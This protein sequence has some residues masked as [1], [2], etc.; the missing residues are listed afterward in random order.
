MKKSDGIPKLVGRFIS[1]VCLGTI[2]S[3]IS[4]STAKD[5]KTAK[6]R[7]SEN[8]IIDYL[9]GG[10]NYNGISLGKSWSEAYSWPGIT[11]DPP[12]HNF[13]FSPYSNY[14]RG[15]EYAVSGEVV[16]GPVER[17]RMMDLCKKYWKYPEKSKYAAQLGKEYGKLMQKRENRI[18]RKLKF[19]KELYTY[20][21]TDNIKNFNRQCQRHSSNMVLHELRSIGRKGEGGTPFWRFFCNPKEQAPEKI[22]ICHIKYS[23]HSVPGLKHIY[24]V[25]Y[26]DSTKWNND[27][28]PYCDADARWYLVTLD[29]EP[30][31]LRLEGT[32][33][34]ILITGIINPAMNIAYCEKKADI[35]PRMGLY[36]ESISR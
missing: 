19:L 25:I 9:R 32:G 24:P 5:T 28:I 14:R 2:I 3:L 20:L 29:K 27:K 22:Q 31:F 18:N 8:V 13:F 6:T 11:M 16:D 33:N 7:L 21:S 35:I 30:V 34:F 23:D 10:N 17:R 12:D 4:C 36:F 26:G 15:A 1:I